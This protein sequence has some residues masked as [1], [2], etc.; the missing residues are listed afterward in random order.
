LINEG[1][2][3]SSKTRKPIL[4]VGRVTRLRHFAVTDYGNA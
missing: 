4:D 2:S 1:V 3:G